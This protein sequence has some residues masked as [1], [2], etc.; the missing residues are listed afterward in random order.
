MLALILLV[1]IYSTSA[2]TE[3]LRKYL[4]LS[5]YWKF[6][7]GDDSK[8][9]SPLYD[10]AGWDQ[11][12]IPGQ[13]ENQGYNE[14]NGYAWYR[15]T[16]KLGEIPGKTPLYLMLGRIDDA[17]EVYLTGKMLGKSGSFPPNFETAYNRTRKYTIPAGYLK[18]NAENSIAIRVYDSYLEGGIVDGPTG[19]Y[20]DA[21]NEL[22]SLKLYEYRH[23]VTK[24]IV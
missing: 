11:I 3:D 7:I 22:L 10:D 1:L 23:C 2:H 16:F 5:G 15:K 9:A 20:F 18:E 24:K 19:L 6:S 12:T 8:W 4:S 17:D 21:D 13:W 14:Y